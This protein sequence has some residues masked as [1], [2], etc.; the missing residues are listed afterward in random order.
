MLGSTSC[1]PF[2]SFVALA[3]GGSWH[4]FAPFGDRSFAKW[5]HWCIFLA[6]CGSVARISDGDLSEEWGTLEGC[7]F[8]LKYSITCDFTRETVVEFRNNQRLKVVRASYQLTSVLAPFCTE[9][10][11][12]KSLSL[13]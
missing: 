12:S 1:L 8:L 9:K 7:W 10:L 2:T 5:R 6:Q 4:G 11:H 3:D 13:H